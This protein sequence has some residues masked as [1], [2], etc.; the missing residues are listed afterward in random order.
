M[1]DL[2]QIPEEE[3]AVEREPVFSASGVGHNFGMVL[4]CPRLLLRVISSTPHS[5]RNSAPKPMETAKVGL[6]FTTSSTLATHQ[7]Q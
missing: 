3:Q 7:P 1:A 6:I 2:G 4:A 5:L